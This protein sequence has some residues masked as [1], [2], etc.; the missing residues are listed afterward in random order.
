MKKHDVFA[1]LRWRYQIVKG[2]GS[3]YLAFNGLLDYSA[4]YNLD[5]AYVADEYKWSLGCTFLFDLGYVYRF[6]DLPYGIEFSYSV[7]VN[8]THR[9]SELGTYLIA[10]HDYYRSGMNF[11]KIGMNYY[12]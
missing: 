7:G 4:D 5:E 6:K 9:S 2:N 10:S 3:P 1:G 12:F 8:Y 11:L